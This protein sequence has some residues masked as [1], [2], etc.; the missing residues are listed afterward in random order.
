MNRWAREV[1]E[2]H[3]DFGGVKFET[4]IKFGSPAQKICRHGVKEGADLILTSTHGRTGL[5]HVLLGSTAEQIIR[6]ARLPVLVVP[7]R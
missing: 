5:S 7:G 2:G 3:I 1:A 4:E 6:Y